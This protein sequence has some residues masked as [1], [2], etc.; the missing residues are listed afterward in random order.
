MDI[1]GVLLPERARFLPG[2]RMDT[3]YLCAPQYAD[4][5]WPLSTDGR[6]KWCPVQRKLDPACVSLLRR[7]VELSGARLVASTSWRTH[8]AAGKARIENALVEAGFDPR[9]HW[10]ERW[11]TPK[12]FG[13]ARGREINL[14]LEE[15]GEVD[16]WVA[17]DDERELP[18][19]GGLVVNPADG[20]GLQ[21]YGAALALLDVDDPELAGVGGWPL[22]TSYGDRGAVRRWLDRAFARGPDSDR[23]IARAVPELIRATDYSPW[24]HANGPSGF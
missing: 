10:H 3:P 13:G 7:L 12:T 9:P 16:R 1:D 19:P 23:E 22:W 11:S 2:Q 18:A 6:S 8:P 4:P 5:E 21:A 14:W 20:L 17:L 15:A 24:R